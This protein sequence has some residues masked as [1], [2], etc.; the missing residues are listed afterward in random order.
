MS[1]IEINFEEQCVINIRN[2][3][4]TR[5]ISEVDYE[6]FNS[7]IYSIIHPDLNRIL[8]EFYGTRLLVRDDFISHHKA[9]TNTSCCLHKWAKKAPAYIIGVYRATVRNQHEKIEHENGELYIL[10][11]DMSDYPGK[12]KYFYFQQY[13]LL[14]RTVYESYRTPEGGNSSYSYLVSNPYTIQYFRPSFSLDI[15][16]DKYKS[17]REQLRYLGDG[18]YVLV[19]Q[20]KIE[21]KRETSGRMYSGFCCLILIIVFLVLI[22]ILL[23]FTPRSDNHTGYNPSP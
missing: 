2:E 9:L 7:Q 23:Y 21:I 3:I 18:I 1:D 11:S 5:W 6:F 10:P 17:F 20:S 22:G 19:L 16:E 15:T 4:H 12:I 14:L 8:F 13:H